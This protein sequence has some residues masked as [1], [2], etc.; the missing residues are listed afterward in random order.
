MITC[1]F[2]DD[3]KGT[4]RHVTVGALAVNKKK[5]VLLIKRAD[6]LINGGKYALPGGFLDRDED[7]RE[8][9]IRELKEETGLDGTIISLFQIIDTPNDQRRIDK[10]FSLTTL[11]K[12]RTEKQ[13]TIRR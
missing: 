5:Q 13:M 4:L 10:M 12:Y 1:T 7:T 2:E 11:L 8:A 9:T 6:Y 3:G